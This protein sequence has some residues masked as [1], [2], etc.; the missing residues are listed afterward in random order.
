MT[1]LAYNMEEF[2]V[3]CVARHAELAGVAARPTRVA[4]PFLGGGQASRFDR[5]GHCLPVLRK[6][7]RG[8]SPDAAAI[9]EVS[10]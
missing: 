1:T 3:S 7:T 8:V 2:F 6:T 9:G 5:H 10:F 4:T